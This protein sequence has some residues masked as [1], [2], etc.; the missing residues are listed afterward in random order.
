MNI[1]TLLAAASFAL[2]GLANAQDMVVVGHPSAAALSKDQV[3][4][5]FL[6]KS[7]ALTPLDLNDSSPLYAAFY[8]K[9][10]GREV[11]QVKSTWSR[12][13]F[14]GK[15]QPPKQL[16]DAAAVK[17]AVAADPKAVGY[18]EKSAVDGSVKV[19]LALD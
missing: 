11:A 13:V 18:I 9:A 7:Q 12:V 17:K 16:P 14:T 4:D 1:R 15:G 2:A 6:G 19:L 8:R 3:A 10:T 5:L